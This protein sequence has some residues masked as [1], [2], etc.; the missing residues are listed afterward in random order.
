MVC[1]E[2]TIL[3]LKSVFIDP[4][5]RTTKSLEI[6]L[7]GE[8]MRLAEREYGNKDVA[9]CNYFIQILNI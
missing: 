7:K 4:M 9:D 8:S 6:L 2:M 1:I 3:C 5:P